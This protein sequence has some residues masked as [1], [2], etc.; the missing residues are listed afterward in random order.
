M[1]KPETKFINFKFLIK[2]PKI[3]VS[4]TQRSGTMICS[5]MICYD[6]GYDFKYVGNNRELT[7]VLL[8]QYNNIVI[9]GPGICR[10]LHEFG[11]RDDT[12]IVFMKRP[13]E[14]IIK[15]QERIN[16]SWEWLEL[17]LYGFEKGIISKVKYDYFYSYQ[18]DK[19]KNLLEINYSDL[20]SHPLWI[21]KELRKNFEPEQWKIDNVT[22]SL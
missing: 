15:S 4:G 5:R 13:I 11:Q 8:N 1:K 18:K 10:W 19:I 22:E 7:N 16:W 12:L 21:P 3:I 20:S 9:H 14:D 6:T 2:Y 17:S